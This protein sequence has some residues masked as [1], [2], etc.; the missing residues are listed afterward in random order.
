[1][2]TIAIRHATTSRYANPVAL[3]SHRL[4]LRPRENRD[5]RLVAFALKIEP[6][7][8]VT[9][10]TDVLGN[11]VAT[12]VFQSPADT[13]TIES[14]ATM[15]LFA[16]AWPVFD[17]A[18]AAINYPFPYRDDI[19][20]DLGALTVRQYPDPD[21][22]LVAWARG[23]VRGPL[24]DTLSLLKDLSNG[25][26]AATAYQ[27]RED[28][29]TQ[30]PLE[31]LGRGTGTCRDYAVLFAE[32]ARGLGFGARIVSGYINNPTQQ[33]AIPGTTHAWAEVY[34]P[35]AGWITFDP[36]NRLVGGANLIP[37]AVARDIH[38]AMPVTGSFIGA[39]D[40]FLGMTVGVEVEQIDTNVPPS[41]PA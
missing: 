31:T 29:G 35:G 40:D 3:G 5:L 28:E 39:T 27:V 30:T 22:R 16:P 13:L 4:M 11:A 7:A 10:A 33:I 32:A 2:T 24:T 15:E 21:N 38:F 26:S 37:V 17:I 19:W 9:W 8:K 20:T 18:A 14:R 6:E 1:M 25:V 34:I 23:F 12:A 41:Q 36:T